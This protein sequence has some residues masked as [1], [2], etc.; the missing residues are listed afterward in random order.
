MKIKDVIH[1][2]IIITDEMIINL[3]HT[4]EFQRLR[5]IKQLGLTN[6]IF[7][8]AEHTR[9]S[10]SLGVYHILKQILEKFKEKNKVFFTNLEERSL[11]VAGLLH[12]LGHG[13]L[14][15]AAENF[16]GYSHEDYTVKIIV[17]EN[18]QINE[19]LKE[20]KELLENIVLFIQKKHSNKP[21]NSLLSS[22]LDADRMDYLVRD[23]YY[24][25]AVY[26]KIELE[27]I[28][29]SFEYENDKIVVFEKMVHTLEDYILSRYHMFVQV[30]LNK[31]SIYYELLVKRI[32][33][34]VFLLFSQ[35]YLFKNNISVFLDLAETNIN[36]ND[37]TQIN[38]YNFLNLISNLEREDDHILK[39][40]VQIFEKQI[41]F[42]ENKTF[43][44]MNENL[45]SSDS[46]NIL[47]KSNDL[48]KF[49]EL[50]KEFLHIEKITKKVYNP[51]EPIYVKKYTSGEIVPIEEISDI[52]KFASEK[53][54]IIIEQS[55]HKIM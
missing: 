12:D 5:K 8:S 39:T 35:N 21:L 36:I 23:S 10:H 17:S 22:S 18:S 34:R 52:F 40:L 53:L 25:G 20:E 51:K 28:I 33:E 14:S 6:L 24:T 55:K 3:I 47:D 38:D 44:Y 13:P 43:P 31:K 29:D 49:D 27:R 45:N 42:S 48:N 16:F 37:Y 4:K 30:Y 26:G 7:P 2:E 41:L 11:L 32:L 54:Q 1:G 46:L 15:H 19:I 9:F 50:S